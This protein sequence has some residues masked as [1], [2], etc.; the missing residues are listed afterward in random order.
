VTVSGKDQSE[1]L[2]ILDKRIDAAVM[3]S[4]KSKLTALENTFADLISKNDSCS[5]LEK[6]DIDE[7]VIDK[8]LEAD[9]LCKGASRLQ[10]V[11]R[12]IEHDK[13]RYEMLC[14]RV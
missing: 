7:L 14:E 8:K 2:G 11:Q 13:L 12:E 9:E 4:I 1:E 10:S 5:G 3:D 6:L